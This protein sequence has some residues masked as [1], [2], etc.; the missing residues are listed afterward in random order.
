MD[1]DQALTLVR[2]FGVAISA[3]FA[4][5][6]L[7]L[8]GSF[9]YGQPDTESD[10]DVAVALE[11]PPEDLF[12]AEKRLFRI[13]RSIDTRIEPII[14]DPDHDPSGFATIVRERGLLV[15]GEGCRPTCTVHRH[16]G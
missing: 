13:R 12:A 4:V 8:Y 1:K 6:E 10:I 16:D 14:I 3:E 5:A 15:M 9:A 2:N 11:S 7:W